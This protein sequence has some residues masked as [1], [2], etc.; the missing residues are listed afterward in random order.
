LDDTGALED[1]GRAARSRVIGHSQGTSSDNPGRLLRTIP[2]IGD[3][4]GLTIAAE[5]AAAREAL[6]FSRG[7]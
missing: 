6:R 3:L 2:G 7:W 4:L 5:M 1:R